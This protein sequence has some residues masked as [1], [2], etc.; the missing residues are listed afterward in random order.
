MPGYDCDR[1]L[2]ISK[3]QTDELM[4][5]ICQAI[6]CQPMV[7]QCCQQLFCSDCINDWLRDHHTC[8]YDRQLLAADKLTYPP[9]VLVNIVS[10]LRI[11]CDY[12]DQGCH[13]T[14]PVHM[15]AKHVM[16][17]PYN[18]VDCPQC[19]CRYTNTSATTTTTTTTP[20]NTDTDNNSQH[21]CVNSL[22]ALNRMANTEI[23]SMLSLVKKL[24]MHILNSNNMNTMDLEKFDE[25]KKLLALIQTRLQQ[26][27]CDNVMLNSWSTICKIIYESNSCYTMFTEQFINNNGLDTFVGCMHMFP[28]NLELMI[29]MLSIIMKVS[30]CPQLIHKLMKPELI[31]TF[32]SNLDFNYQFISYSSAIILTNI[33]SLGDQFWSQYLPDSYKC[34]SMLYKLNKTIG[35]WKIN[36]KQLKLNC[37]SLKPILNLLK[38]CDPNKL[39]MLYWPVWTLAHL[40][41]INSQR[42]CPLLLNE[43]GI[44]IVEQLLENQCL[45]YHIKHLIKLILYQYYRYQQTGELSDLVDSDNMDIPIDYH[46]YVNNKQQ[47]QQQ[48]QQQCEIFPKKQLPINRILFLYYYTDRQSAKLIQKSGYIRPSPAYDDYL[49]GIYM[50]TMAPGAADGSSSSS[51]SNI[52]Q[53]IISMHK[54]MPGHIKINST[55]CYIVVDVGKL[56]LGKLNKIT[57]TTTMYQYADTILVEPG[58]VYNWPGSSS[59]SNDDDKL[60]LIRRTR[61]KSWSNL[62]H[63]VDNKF[64]NNINSIKTN[65]IEHSIE[66]IESNEPPSLL[67]YYTNMEIAQSIK[68]TGA[69]NLSYTQK[70]LGKY[71]LLC[72]LEPVV[73]D[74]PEILAKYYNTGQSTVVP[75]DCQ[76]MADWCVRVWTKQLSTSRLTGLD[77]HMYQYSGTIRITDPNDVY[78]K[79]ECSKRSSIGKYK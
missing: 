66:T 21:N 60:T 36:T 45:S 57:T 54:N 68:H 14:V 59:S 6:V 49:S 3:Q 41:R 42:Y 43:N 67:Y 58:M 29:K 48:Q 69:I 35:S 28:N 22:I 17:C 11:T 18:V 12:R 33:A 63:D 39:E 56:D 25:I 62:V 53:S 51:S 47:Q 76:D 19:H 37:K 55:D 13:H 30:E 16:E 38:M 52:A 1:F 77:N 4:C 64:N 8:P 5:C 73:N 74:K 75:N 79:P 31:D 70:L 50:T 44:E 26:N 2:D 20:N 34:D 72:P 27:I 23:C 9:K 65:Q 71:T 61:S 32:V 24:T 40:T 7:A 10:N 15:L 78:E 46:K